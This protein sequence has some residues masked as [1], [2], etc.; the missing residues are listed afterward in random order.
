M[1][2]KILP[3]KEFEKDF[4]K[5]GD[6]KAQEAIKKKIEEVSKD[7]SRYKRL[8]YDLKGSFRIR[9]GSFRVVYSFNE[10]L[11]EMYPEKIVLGHKY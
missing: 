2:Y 6:M 9:I 8:H 4:K 1:P 11:K 7:P 5:I 3:T 10:L